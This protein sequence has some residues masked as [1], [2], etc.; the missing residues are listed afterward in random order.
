MA[1]SSIDRVIKKLNLILRVAPPQNKKKKK[2]KHVHVGDKN[3]Q[4]RLEVPNL[5]TK[6]GRGSLKEQN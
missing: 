1:Q 2:K 5:R 4:Q 6:S 3:L